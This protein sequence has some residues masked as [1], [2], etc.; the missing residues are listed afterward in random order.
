MQGI[1]A[2][3]QDG[4]DVNAV[5]RSPDHKLLASGDDYGF[6]NVFRL[7]T[8]RQLFRLALLGLHWNGVF[9]GIRYPSKALRSSFT[10]ATQR[11]CRM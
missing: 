8:L 6:V 7:E 1:Y 3:D 4:T 5:D 10:A 11:T 9:A 2:P